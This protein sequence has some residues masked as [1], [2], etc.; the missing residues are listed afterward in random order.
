MQKVILLQRLF[1]LAMDEEAEVK[2]QV[3]R[4]M[5]TLLEAR[6]EVLYGDLNNIIVYMLMRTQDSDELVAL[7]ACEFWLSISDNTV[8]Q[9][10]LAP[11]L[12]QLVPL[13]LDR[14]RYSAMDIA[15]L[16]ADDEE[17]E[18]KP[19]RAED[20]RPRFHKAKTHSFDHVPGASGGDFSSYSI[21][22]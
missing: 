13:L 2:K 14:M 17:D 15:F 16:R 8:C 18:M 11:H 1:A 7:E 5:V 10:A 22:S 12:P 9:Q 3:L 21:F 19:D 20:I 6:P 4:A